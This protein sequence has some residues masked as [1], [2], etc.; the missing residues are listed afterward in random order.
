MIDS[1]FWESGSD[2][3]NYKSRYNLREIKKKKCAA[4]ERKVTKIE[5][6]Q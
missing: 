3:L 5:I 6:I 4:I 2:S 1:E